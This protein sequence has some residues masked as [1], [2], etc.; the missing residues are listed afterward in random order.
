[1]TS[2]VLAQAPPRPVE[3][4]R[5]YR[6]ELQGLRAI[7]ALLVVVYHVWLGRVSGGVDA[8]FLISGFLVTGQL[9]RMAER[10]GVQYRT[11][12]LNTAKRLFPA[13][14][15]VLLVTVIGSVMFLPEHRWPVT[16]E[17]VFA[18]LLL[19]ENWQLTSA[20]TDYFNSH[21]EASP[22]QHFWSLS[23]QGQIY[24]TWPLLVGAAALA[25]RHLRINATRAVA[26]VLTLVFALS[27]AHSVE[28]TNA[29]QPL[30]YFSTTT[31]LWEFALGGLL[32]LA[33]DKVELPAR[34][35]LAL[36]WLGVL[37]LA[38]CG[39]LLQVGTMFPG[40]AALWPTVATSLVLLAGHTGSPI[41]ADRLLSTRPLRYLGD[42]SYSLYLWHWPI[43]VLYLVARDRTEVGLLGGLGII[44]L[45]LLLAAFT[46]RYVERPTR[47]GRFR[48]VAAAMVPVIAATAVW[49]LTSDRRLTG[50]VAEVSDD[51]HPGAIA[52]TEGYA[53]AGDDNARLVPPMVAMTDQWSLIPG[54]SCERPDPAAPQLEVC[55]GPADGEP[56]RKV[57]IVG[58]SHAQQY[59]EAFLPTAERL[60]WQLITMIKGA[61]PFSTESETVRGDRDCE[62]WNAAAAERIVDLKPD[63]VVTMATRTIRLDHDEETPD[64]FV[65]Q[66]RN[67]EEA[68]IPVVAIRDSPRYDYSPSECAARYGAE[69][70]RCVMKRSDLL[71]LTIGPPYERRDDIPA[72]VSFLDFTD[73]YCTADICPPAI[74]NVLLY[75]DDN[76]LTS[77]YMLTMNPIVEPAVLG[78][79]GWNEE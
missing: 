71:A 78:A 51:S 60:N 29:N 26:V 72:N 42:I 1:M 53:Y 58:D 41:G 40:W 19:L 56:T 22:V 9:T 13:A 17:E 10:G 62:D 55:T 65:A 12:W 39:M 36:G 37:M 21:V 4:K 45:S 34:L 14:S 63:A 33:I 77:S 79:L 66:W 57:V 23:V 69:D 20:A 3:G 38:S 67:L 68:G 24:L 47:K 27:L 74:G 49:Q 76:H 59:T 73:Y 44:T 70:E 43:L 11:Y 32:A 61:C 18:S 2:D 75:F 30:A 48:L 7:A 52:R 64:G 46:H 31:R 28:L 54:A 50:Y 35:R 15:A 16:V 25:A 8:F 5:R 6:T